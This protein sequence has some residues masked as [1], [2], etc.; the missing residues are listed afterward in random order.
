MLLLQIV[1]VEE[2]HTVLSLSIATILSFV[3][4]CS[5]EEWVRKTFCFV[6]T[7]R[8]SRLML[9]ARLTS[10]RAHEASDGSSER[11]SVGVQVYKSIMNDIEYCSIQGWVLHGVLTASGNI[12]KKCSHCS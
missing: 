11:S 9:C 3:D 10:L 8:K 12:V 2:E 1:S 5:G 7:Q 6:G 4:L